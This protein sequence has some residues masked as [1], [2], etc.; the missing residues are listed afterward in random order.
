MI[1]VKD[2]I[3]SLSSHPTNIIA[4]AKQL[5]RKVIHTEHPAPFDVGKAGDHMTQSA[6]PIQS[7]LTCLMVCEDAMKTIPKFVDFTAVCR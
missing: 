4:K 2:P 5:V 7:K 3:K 1:A 6:V